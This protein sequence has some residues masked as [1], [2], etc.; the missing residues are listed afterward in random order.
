MPTPA[1]EP[2]PSRPQVFSRTS[3][4]RRWDYIVIGSGIGGMTAAALLAKTDKRVL[5]LEQH[6]Q[7]GGY[8]HTF[9]RNGYRWDVGLHAVSEVT[10]RDGPGVLLRR[11]TD[12]R[13]EWAS[14][15][16]TYDAFD[17]PGG[18][19]V[20]FPNNPE[21][22]R[23]VVGRK[24]P[25]QARAIRHYHKLLDR[26]HAVLPGFFVPRM[27]PPTYANLAERVFGAPARHYA[28]QRTID[29]MRR[30]TSDER[31]QRV[32][33]AQWGYYGVP[34][35]RSSFVMHALV[36]YHYLGGAYYPVGGSQRIAEELLRP[37]ADADGW[38]RVGAAVDEILVEKGTA[39]GVRLESG[40][41]IRSRRIIS[42]VGAVPTVSRL[43]PIEH[44]SAP[45]AQ[46]I[47]RLAP[48]CAHVGLYLGLKG[49]ITK[50]GA[51]ANNRWFYETWDLDFDGWALESPDRVPPAE[52]TY[53]SFGTLKDPV[54]DPGPDQRHTCTVLTIVPWQVFAP[55]RDRPWRRRGKEYEAFK[56]RLQDRMMERLRERFPGLEQMIDYAELSTPLSTVHFSRAVAGSMYGVAGTPE[57]YQCRWLRN[58]TPIENLFL[59][60]SDTASPGIIG[61]WL[62]GVMPALSAEPVGVI[63]YLAKG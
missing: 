11:L 12:G 52:L 62:G 32:L 46:A 25:G 20:A 38:T 60:G 53:F 23:E 18:F 57:R 19:H 56:Q 17:F 4:D 37:V 2:R 33:T 29:V 49:D 3:P 59:G 40:E 1:P 34:P 7:P 42:A 43:L 51:T 44:R 45:W 9:K 14:L 10:E 61:A 8:T 41:T 58:R 48:S 22:Y 26:V 6:T 54:H 39:V 55:W 13:L 28:N 24:F 50:V 30:L 47:N 27:L 16:S 21:E 63:R 35:A 31:L 15:G 36:M 5:V